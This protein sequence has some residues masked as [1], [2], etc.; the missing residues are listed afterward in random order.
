MKN[1]ETEINLGSG[2]NLEM[3]SSRLVNT[4]QTLYLNTEDKGTLSLSVEISADFDSIPE[5]YHEVFLN[6]MSAKYLGR[7]SFGDNPFSQCQPAPKR[8]WY[9]FWKSKTLSI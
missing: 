8:K 5:E 3:R 4:F 6:M 7:V 1:K 2:N 9:Q